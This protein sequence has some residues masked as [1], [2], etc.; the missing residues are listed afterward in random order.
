MFYWRSWHRHLQHPTIST[1]PAGPQRHNN[2]KEKAKPKK[3]ESI[4]AKSKKS[5]K[6]R[7]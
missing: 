4:K 6:T 2:K 5:N 3:Q 1:L 7:N